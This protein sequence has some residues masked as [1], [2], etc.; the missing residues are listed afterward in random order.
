[1]PRRAPAEPPKQVTVACT[2]D[3]HDQCDGECIPWRI[4]ARTADW[5]QADIETDAPL[6]CRCSCHTEKDKP[7]PSSTRSSRTK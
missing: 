6:P 3:A 1:M 7:C 5:G 2:H 4:T